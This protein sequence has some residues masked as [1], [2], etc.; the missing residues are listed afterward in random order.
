MTGSRTPA[1]SPLRVAVHV[2]LLAALLAW[3]GSLHHGLGPR[4]DLGVEWYSPRGFLTRAVLASS[5]ESLLATRWKGFLVFWT[6]ALLLAIGCWWTTRSALLRTLAVSAA[7]A[8]GIFVFYAL[9][10]G[11]S[12]V[13]WMLFHWRASATMLALAMVVGSVLLA[14]WLAASWLELGWPLRV[15]TFLPVA[16]GVIAIER[17]VTGTDP[18]LPFAIS[19]WPVVPVFGLE[20]VGTI[21]AS[22]LAGAALGLAG[23]A[24]RKRHH[25]RVGIGLVVA[26]L[27][28]PA[29]WLALGSQGFLP[30]QVA[31]RGFGIATILCGAVLAVTALPAADAARLR[32]RARI[33]GTAALLLGLPLL[34]G[35]GWARFDY[36]RNRDVIAQRVIDGL[37]DFYAREQMYPDTLAELVE[38]G[39][40]EAVPTPRVGFRWLDDDSRFTYQGFGTSYLLEFPAPR[41]VQCTYNPPYDDLEDDESGADA[42][43]DADEDE[44]LGGAWSCPTKPPELW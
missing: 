11:S 12:Q 24:L 9:G 22:L 17:G 14:P 41:W 31:A 4:P 6:P 33:L 30:F 18:K 25:T 34:G 8:A 15:L 28:L 21:V 1:A 2:G 32:Q 5:W 16:L 38:S 40:L 39:E 20:V 23:L 7:L 29:G 13:A 37:A 36:S 43:A 19:P 3:T 10:G 26:G 44:E 35:Q 42:G 27:A